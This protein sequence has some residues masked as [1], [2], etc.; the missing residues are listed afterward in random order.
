VPGGDGGGE[1]RDEGG[2]EGES[3]ESNYNDTSCAYGRGGYL[4][5]TMSQ[6]T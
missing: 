2:I 4:I 1:E 3:S 6:R 5:G